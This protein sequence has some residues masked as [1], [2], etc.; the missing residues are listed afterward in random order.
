MRK[1]ML[2]ILSLISLSVSA[3]ETE[4]NKVLV[5]II[6]QINAIM[7]LIEE[8]K[9]VQPENTR[10]KFNLEKFKNNKGE[11]SNGIR[12]DLLEI[13]NG[14]VEYINKP[15]LAPKTIKSLEF[16]FVEDRG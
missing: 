14:I 1:T 7:P 3:N 8:A 16:D 2:I 5:Q 12:E 11:D 6:N 15:D 13:K 9:N 4:M 10:I